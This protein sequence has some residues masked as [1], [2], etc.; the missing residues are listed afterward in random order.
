MKIAVISD[1]H[2]NFDALSALPG[3]YDELWVLGDLVNYGP[4]PAE[5]VD[6]ISQRATLV[7]R[8]NH[9]HC[10]AY[11]EDPRCTP[12]FRAMATAT[13]K[14]TGQVLSDSQ[15]QFLHDLPLRA[16][17]ERGN[18]HFCLL[19]SAPSNPLYGHYGENSDRW[20]AEAES[21]TADVLFV[22][23]THRP[24][25]RRIGDRTVCNPGSLGQPCHGKPEACYV[26]WEDGSME[27]KSFAYPVEETVRKI[28]TMP[29]EEKIRREL[30]KVLRKGK[31]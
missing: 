19:H 24:F 21:I 12:R 25:L 15:K 2:A 23:H 3:G 7:V 8:G 26:L 29:V 10:I 4:Q 31:P 13:R 9:D 22:G 17:V 1:I 11:D 14:F 27:L 28:F 18:T 5:V 16:D 30:A 20:P 6:Y